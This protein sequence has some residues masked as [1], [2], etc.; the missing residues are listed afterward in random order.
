MRKNDQVNLQ[1]MG[2]FSEEK[3]ESYYNSYLFPKL[4]SKSTAFGG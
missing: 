4:L 3:Q 1:F 2:E